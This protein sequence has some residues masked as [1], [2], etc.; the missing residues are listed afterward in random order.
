M[1]SNYNGQFDGN[2]LV[3]GRTVCCKTTF[4]KKHGLNNF[5]GEIIKT[6]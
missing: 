6:E 2:V 1:T 3:V 4:L 5:F